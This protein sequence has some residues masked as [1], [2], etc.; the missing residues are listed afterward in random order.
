MIFVHNIDPAKLLKVYDEDTYE[1]I[2]AEWQR[3]YLETHYLRVES[4]GGSGDKGRDI[5]CTDKSNNIIVFQCKYYDRK[6][7]RQDAMIEIAKCC[8]YCFMGE[9]KIESKTPKKF[10]LVAPQGVTVALR[11]FLRSPEE[12]RTEL[13]KNWSSHYSKKISN[14]KE[15][16]LDSELSS[17]IDK[18]DFAIFDYVS[19][20]EFID[21]FKKTP[22]YTKRF[23]QL[24]KPRKLITIAPEHIR[25]D[26]LTYIK[27]I[28]DAYS[29][30]LS[31]VVDDEKKLESIDPK[32]K[33]DFDNQRL[34]FYSAEYLAAHSRE[35]Y[36]PEQQY[37]EQMK[38]EVY[39]GI[40]EYIDEDAQNGFERLK[41]VLKRAAE[42]TISPRNQ[43]GSVVN[44]QDK[45]GICHHLAN[46]RVGVKWKK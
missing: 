37:F 31:I 34:Y 3:H 6:L 21:E 16:M 39:H 44:I 43:L 38:E 19:P 12:I 25:D 27:K 35:T 14:S 8:Y 9:Y 29:D 30:K 13:K 15:I 42:L 32:L 18:M 24:H 1:Q 11:D 40:I 7:N 46:E 23:G 36:A 41:K 4:L 17:F 10:F 26:E 2:I 22:Y 20:E 33:E 5:V 28:L 45:K